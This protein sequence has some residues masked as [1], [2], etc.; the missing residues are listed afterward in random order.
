MIVEIMSTSSSIESALRF[1]A[2]RLQ[3]IRVTH[4]GTIARRTN[5]SFFTRGLVF[6][7]RPIRINEKVTFKLMELSEG[8]GGFVYVGFTSRDPDNLQG[9]T[10][11][12]LAKGSGF[13]SWFFPKELCGTRSTLFYYIGEGGEVHYGV[14]GVE[15]GLFEGVVRTNQSLWPLFDIFGNSSGV[16]LIEAESRETRPKAR[17]NRKLVP[18]MLHETHSRNVRIDKNVAQR[19]DAKYTQGYIFS[20]QPIKSEQSIVIQ[21]APNGR[22]RFQGFV[23]LG[24]TS[25]DPALLNRDDLPDN[26]NSL[27]DRPEYWV[28]ICDFSNL[29]CGDEIGLDLAHDGPITFH[30]NGGKFKGVVHVDATLK[31]YLFVNVYGSCQDVHLSTCAEQS[32]VEEKECVVCYDNVIEAALY[33]CGHT[34]M[35]FECAVEQWQGKGD[36]HCPLCR[37]VIR[38]VIRIN[39]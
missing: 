17:A 11:Q 37:A 29:N 5:T 20:K 1:R 26:V 12:H 14:D 24:V 36:G 34:C 27:V 8:L 35:C 32:K 7:N 22:G 9:V 10:C 28:L 15:K 19:L 6:T 30:L 16:R 33:R 4:D 3:N 38:D 23:H 39:K 21:I 13:W 18:M 2:D 25:C 31:L